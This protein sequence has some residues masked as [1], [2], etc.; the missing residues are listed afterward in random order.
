ME[1]YSQNGESKILF[2]LFNQ[3]GTTNKFF[4]DL[5]AG[6]GYH[7]SNTQMFKTLGWDGLQI[8]IDNKGNKEVNRHLITKENILSLLTKTYDVP[9][10]FDLLSIDLDGND[11][12]ILNEILMLLAPSVIVLEVNSQLGL[13]KSIT[14]PYNPNHMWDGTNAYGMSYKAAF[15]LLKEHHYIIYDIVNN[16]NIIATRKKVTPLPY[17]YGPTWSHPE[18]EITWQEV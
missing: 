4:V 17:K 14:M 15:K 16:T 8:D 7:L 12:H 1:D 11:F 5:G 9:I 6:D 3:I 13:D 10:F 18:K 2:K